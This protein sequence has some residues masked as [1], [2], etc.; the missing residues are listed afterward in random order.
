[1]VGGQPHGAVALVAGRR[2]A[3]AA[4]AV[5]AAHKQLHDV[6]PD[7]AIRIHTPC[8]AALTL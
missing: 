5:V 3:A 7:G 4:L 8:A 6:V 2:R 1:M